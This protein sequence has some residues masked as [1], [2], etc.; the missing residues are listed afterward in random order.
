M[1]SGHIT[2]KILSYAETQKVSHD[3]IN[4]QTVK[5]E[6]ILTSVLDYGSTCFSKSSPR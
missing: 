3:F 2:P 6:V 5:M 4:K 1:P